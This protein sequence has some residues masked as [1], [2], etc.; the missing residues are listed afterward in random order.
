MRDA[1]GCRFLRPHVNKVTIYYTHPRRLRACVIPSV[2]SN[3]IVIGNAL[4]I[5]KMFYQFYI[6]QLTKIICGKIFLKNILQ[7]K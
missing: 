2:L 5:P 7:Q 3:T 6:E 4:S 1:R